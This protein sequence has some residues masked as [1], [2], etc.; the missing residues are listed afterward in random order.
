MRLWE[1]HKTKRKEVVTIHCIII[2]KLL[3]NSSDDIWFEISGT[4]SIALLTSA[5][6][7]LKLNNP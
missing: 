5:E 6:G 3:I 2:G 4:D 1:I 7:A